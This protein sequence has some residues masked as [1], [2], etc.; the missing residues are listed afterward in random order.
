MEENKL[1]L[2]QFGKAYKN[3]TNKRFKNKVGFKDI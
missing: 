1:N 3:N 2:Y